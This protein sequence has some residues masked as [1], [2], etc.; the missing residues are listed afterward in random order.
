MDRRQFL[1]AAAAVPLLAAAPPPDWARLR[2]ALKGTL[3]LPGDRAYGTAR[4]LFNPSFDRVRPGG[5]A[6][7]ENPADVA[8]C[9]SFARAAGVPVHVRSG[10]HSYAGWSTGPGLVVDVARMNDVGYRDGRAVVGA[11]ARLVDVYERLAAHGA[12]IPAGT[13]PTVG[14]AGL[15]LGGGIGVVSRKYGLTCDALESVRIVTADG[16]LLTC[17]AHH[18]AGLYWAA[19]GGG[20]GNVGVAVSFTFLTHRAGR[21]TVFFAGW[22]W[23]KAGAVLR[24]WQSWAVEAPDE[25]WS[26]LHLSRDRGELTVE[27]AGVYLGRSDALR[28]LLRPLTSRVA[29]SWVSARDTSHLRAM[30]TM[31]GCSGLTPSQC[32]LPG[33]TRDGRLSR[34]AFVATSHVAYRPLSAEGVRALVDQVARRGSHMVLLDA[35]GGAIAR[36]PAGATAFPHRQALFSVQYYASGSDRSWI[37]GARAAMRPHLGEHA[38]V[39]YIDPDI[40]S[41]REAYYGPNAARLAQVKAAYD[42]GRVFRLPQGF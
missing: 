20:G 2:R 24:A 7:C 1:Q 4:R 13:C 29:P 12:S 34:A 17:D 14:I 3:V 33:Q 6:Y 5:V 42:P 39:N 8:A 38:Y 23:S 16:R 22:P 27:L 19:R 41:W 35:M 32:H 18:H 30:M 10:G 40:A 28:R 36:V 21:V 9:L 25:L 11:G 15:T 26:T 31:A 37:R